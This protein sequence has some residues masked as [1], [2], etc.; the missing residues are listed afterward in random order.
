MVLVE[1]DF[2]ASTAVDIV[3]VGAVGMEVDAWS[4]TRRRGE[5]SV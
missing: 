5:E 1:A 2:A 3:M 4:G